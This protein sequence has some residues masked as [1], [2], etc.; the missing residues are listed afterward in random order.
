MKGKE[1]GKKNIMFFNLNQRT[2][3]VKDSLMLLNNNVDCISEFLPG[4]HSSDLV[5]G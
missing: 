3:T 5:K 2:N 4:A 1:G